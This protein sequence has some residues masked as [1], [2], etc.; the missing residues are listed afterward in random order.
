MI[1]N[2]L[3]TVKEIHIALPWDPDPSARDQ[4]VFQLTANTMNA[5]K[6]IGAR[7]GVSFKLEQIS[8][9]NQKSPELAHL[10]ANLFAYPKLEYPV[11]VKQISLTQ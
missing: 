7:A 8:K 2:L 6:D 3:E 1:G 4:E 5:I 9:Q 11:A 10:E